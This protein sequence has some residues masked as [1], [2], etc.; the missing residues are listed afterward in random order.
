MP[1][2]IQ[3]RASRFKLKSGLHFELRSAWLSA[4][5]LLLLLLPLPSPPPPRLKELFALE[6]C[7]KVCCAR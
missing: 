2:H 4:P 5:L 7:I 6:C 1:P 3:N